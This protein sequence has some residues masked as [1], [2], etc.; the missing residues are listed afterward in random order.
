MVVPGAPAYLNPLNSL[1][2]PSGGFDSKSLKILDPKSN[3]W[4]SKFTDNSGT[5]AVVDGR[6]VFT[7]TDGQSSEVSMKSLKFKVADPAGDEVVGTFSIIVGDLENLPEDLSSIVA[8]EAPNALVVPPGEAAEVSP[9]DIFPTF[10]GA[11]L[12]PSKFGFDSPTGPKKKKVVPEGTWVIENG[13]A[14][15][16]PKTGFVGMVRTT[17]SIEDAD[18]VVQ[19]SP[20]SIFVGSLSVNGRPSLVDQMN[21]TKPGV[22]AWLNP[23]AG[24]VPSKGGKFV[25]S[26]IYMLNGSSPLTYAISPAGRWDLLAG[27]L[28]FTPAPGFLGKTSIRFEATDTA[29]RTAFAVATVTVAEDITLPATGS[30]SDQTTSV[31]FTL[32]V[33]G[34]AMMAV[35]SLRRRRTE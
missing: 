18:G 20:I 8:A 9:S 31:A 25:V 28:R 27:N 16:K 12:L 13:V 10:G 7:P 11:K 33:L 6:V 26:S 24:A 2:P 14:K 22:P 35:L 21:W 30:R 29:G 19:K 34:M 5:Y 3:E 17:V 15:F 32:L 4:T 1:T 23:L